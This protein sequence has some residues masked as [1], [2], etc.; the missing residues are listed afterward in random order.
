MRVA[1]MRARA[2]LISL[3]RWWR[4][5]LSMGTKCSTHAH[6]AGQLMRLCRVVAIALV[7][8]VVGVLLSVAFSVVVIVGVLVGFAFVAG[9]VGRGDLRCYCCCLC[10]LVLLSL[11]ITIVFS[12]CAWC[13]LLLFVFSLFWLFF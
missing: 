12:V 6:F 11:A 2:L 3:V 13:A 10:L 5:A 7:G 8:V 1:C 4:R 9:L